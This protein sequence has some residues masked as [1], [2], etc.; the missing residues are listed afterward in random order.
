MGEWNW[1]TCRRLSKTSF[2][3]LCRIWTY[4]TYENLKGPYLKLLSRH[5]GINHTKPPAGPSSGLILRLWSIHVIT[6][7]NIFKR[8]RANLSFRKNVKDSPIPNQDPLIRIHSLV[9]VG[10][11]QTLPI[12]WVSTIV[13]MKMIWKR[14]SKNKSP[15]GIPNKFHAKYGKPLERG[16]E[17]E[18]T[19]YLKQHFLTC[20]YNYQN[21]RPCPAWVGLIQ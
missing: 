12:V 9:I 4:E 11:W 3:S 16:E 15:R 1:R 20:K 21:N 5:P 19:T 13:T 2:V 17:Y 7:A 8:Q 10:E 14:L 18:T 6:G